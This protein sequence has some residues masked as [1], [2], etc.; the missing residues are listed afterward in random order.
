M[1]NKTLGTKLLLALVTL[2]VLAYFA[3]QAVRYFSDPLT[4][5]LAYNYEVELGTA[6]SGYVVRDETV[7]ANNASGQPQLQRTE[8]ERVSAGGLVAVV[9]ADQAAVELQQ[10]IQDL[11]TQIGQLQYAQ[12]AALGAEV[13]LRLDEQIFQNIQ[14]YRSALA[15]DRLDQAE[16]YGAELRSLVLKRDYTYSDTADISAQLTELQSQVSA[17]RSQMGASTQRVT[18]PEAGLYSAVV[19]GYE[20]ILTPDSVESLTPSSLADLEPD[21]ALLAAPNVGKLVLG[22]DW[23]YI[24]ALEEGEAA[25]LKESGGLKLRF[26][27]GVS[28]DLD[29]ELVSVSEPENGRVAAVFRGDT[30]LA[31]LTLLRQQSAQVIRAAI[32]GIRVPIEAVRIRERTVTDEN[33]EET[34]LSETGVYCIVGVEARFKPVD[35]LYRGE[36]FALVRSSLDSTGEITTAQEEI[37]LRAGDEVIVTAYDL[38]DGKVVGDLT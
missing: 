12:E 16:D 31:E 15:A 1:K 3:V 25:L 19:D 2:G 18:A 14:D 7:L 10:K 30:Y 28:R 26:A 24:A 6:L 38:Y 22:N 32:E 23:Y 35:V 34:T 5:T 8:G 13:S 20:S 17:L 33:E 36:D 27:K 37:R 29:V 21:E 11:E 4:T 9:Y